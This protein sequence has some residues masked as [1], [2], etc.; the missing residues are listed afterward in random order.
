M[1][2]YS[3]VGPIIVLLA[4]VVVPAFAVIVVWGVLW[5][6]R[7]ARF[8]S[9]YFAICAGSAS[10]AIILAGVLVHFLWPVSPDK[11]QQPLFGDDVGVKVFGGLALMAGGVAALVATLITWGVCEVARITRP[12]TSGGV[13]S[14]GSPFLDHG[15]SDSGHR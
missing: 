3:G 15:R 5:I 13:P 12:S 6:S 10:V 2:N 11:P 7:R 9:W 1:V 8:V 14:E 4:T